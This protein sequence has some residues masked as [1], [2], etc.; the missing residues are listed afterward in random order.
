MT[1]RRKIFL[2]IWP[3]VLKHRYIIIGGTFL[4]ALVSVLAVIDPVVY[5]KMVDVIVTSLSSGDTSHLFSDISGLLG[6]W[7]LLFFVNLVIGFA[8]RYL[9]WSFNNLLAHEFVTARFS[10]MVN[11]SSQRYSSIAQGKAVRTVDDTIPAL[12][13]ISQAI[14]SRMIPTL[15]SFTTVVV[16]GLFLDWR[17]TLVSLIMVPVVVAIGIISW[18]KAEPKQF[19]ISDL[20]GKASRFLGETISNISTISNFARGDSRVRKYSSML[21]KIISRQLKMNV[22]WAFFHGLGDGISLIGRAIVFGVGIYFVAD[23]SVTLGVLITFLGMLSY[24]LTPVQYAISDSLPRIT[25]GW[26][27]LKLL[28]DMIYQENDVVE[29]TNARELKNVDGYIKFDNVSF[30]YIDQNKNTISNIKL[31]IPRGTSCALVGP[32]GAGK[33]T[34]IKLLNRTVDPTSGAVSLDGVTIDEFTLNSLRKKIGVVSQDTLLFHD[35][36]YNN[37]KFVKPSASRDDVEMA[38]KRAEA[39]SFISG[40]PKG[41]NSIVGERGVKLSGGERQRIALA[42]IFLAD[43]PIL[44]LD[45]STSA[46]DSETESR[47]QSTLRKVMKGRTTILVAHRLSTIYLADQIVV[48]RGGRIVDRGTHSELTRKGGLYKKLWNLQAGGYIK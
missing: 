48:M 12:F 4:S 24:I 22:F 45:E 19:A 3:I 28:V 46:L 1:Q 6:I 47:L 37:V 13:G 39:H 15:I 16:I 5:G 26:S 2:L 18:K 43:T 35:T 27:K 17:L 30:A 11:W 7:V 33:T 23:G 10:E 32:S 29:L 34:L 14:L 38:C 41:Y 36:V 9:I 20:W 21:H 25:E 44:I 42:R 40:L 8:G 31:D